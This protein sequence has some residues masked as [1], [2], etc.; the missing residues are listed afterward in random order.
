MLHPIS[1]VIVCMYGC[2]VNGVCT[3]YAYGHATLTYVDP[4]RYASVEA[5]NCAS[6]VI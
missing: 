1:G 2:F 5:K 4:Y 3:R 6:V